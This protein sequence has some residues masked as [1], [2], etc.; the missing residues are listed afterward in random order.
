VKARL[1]LLALASAGVMSG[2]YG[3]DTGIYWTGCYLFA[4]TFP[5]NWT[6]NGSVSCPI[7]YPPPGGGG[8]T[9]YMDFPGAGGSMI[10]T[11]PVSGANPNDYEVTSTL[12]ARSGT[13]IHFLRASSAFRP[14]GRGQLH[15]GGDC[16]SS[17]V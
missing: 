6:Q 16:D 8:Y 14:G 7:V 3:W 2:A 13:H 10:W 11:A 17:L 5:A 9:W 1:I 12:T 4:N 15:I